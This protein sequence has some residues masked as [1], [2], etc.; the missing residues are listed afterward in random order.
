MRLNKKKM[1]NF[2]KHE[3]KEL[4]EKRLYVELLKKSSFDFVF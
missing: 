3:D 2:S 4:G 1:G